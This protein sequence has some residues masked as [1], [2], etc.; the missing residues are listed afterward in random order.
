MPSPD[1]LALT[2]LGLHSVAEHVLGAGL[3]AHRRRIGLRQWPGGFA[4]QEY[5]VDDDGPVVRRLLVVGTELVRRDDRLDGIV[6]E[7]RAPLT[8]VGAA[9]AV[10]RVTP[11]LTAEVYEPETP[12][13]PDADLRLDREAAAHLAAVLAAA[14]AALTV[15]AADVG[16][17][18]PQLWPEHFDLATVAAEVN[19]GVSLGDEDHP[20]PYA[21]V[22]PWSPP[23]LG[24][25]W[26]EPFG[27]SLPLPEVPGVDRL[28]AFFAEGRDRA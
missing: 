21:Y 11:G 8:T 18:E 20:L 13:R 14:Q 19:Y 22:G 24:G 5:P 4:T 15:F 28:T 27:A 23:P 25:Y 26:N 3:W 7:E 12:F 6:D 17:A 9:A 16:A 1:R 10:A 2:R